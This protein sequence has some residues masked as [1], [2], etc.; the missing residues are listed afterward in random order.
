MWLF[1]VLSYSQIAK[2]SGDLI[3]IGDY[4]KIHIDTSV[5]GYTPGPAGPNQKWD[6]SVNLNPDLIISSNPKDTVYC[7]SVP[8][9]YQSIFPEANLMLTHSILYNT[10]GKDTIR[11]K[12]AS[13]QKDSI[14]ARDSIFLKKTNQELLL[15][16]TCFNS[17]MGRWIL[18]Y[19]D[20]E[21]IAIF[22]FNYNTS[23]SDTSLLDY[24]FS[25][26]VM[27]LMDSARTKQIRYIHRIADAY[28]SIKTPFGSYSNV[29]RIRQ[30][31]IQIDSIWYR[32]ITS[33]SW[34]LEL[35]VVDTSYTFEWID[36]SHNVSVLAMSLGA[37]SSTVKSI[38]WL[39]SPVKTKYSTCPDQFPL[40]TLANFKRSPS[41]KRTPEPQFKLDLPSLFGNP[42]TRKK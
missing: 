32:Y 31:V 18:T 19:S 6:F 22:P 38:A 5:I 25:L 11:G 34:K 16:G 27:F 33:Q 14:I 37:D 30:K 17:P 39:A 23:Y 4:V 13:A 1:I 9:A 7:H 10:L 28:G 21:K 29:L 42:G 20:P 35:V 3:T 36:R 24:K 41:V 15:L 8:S 40:M 12:D 26:P 2:S